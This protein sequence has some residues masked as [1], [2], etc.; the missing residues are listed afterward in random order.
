MAGKQSFFS[1]HSGSSVAL[2]HLSLKTMLYEIM[3]GC[4]ALNGVQNQD[5][6]WL[7]PKKIN[8]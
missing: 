2:F 7:R 6:R 4:Q 3:K 1:Q 8:H 5:Q